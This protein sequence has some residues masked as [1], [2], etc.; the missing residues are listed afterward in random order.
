MLSQ[1]VALYFV[2]AFLANM[3]LKYIVYNLQYPPQVRAQAALDLTRMNGDTRITR[4]KNRCAL[5]GR[6]RGVMRDFRCEC[7]HEENTDDRMNRI[8][9]RDMAMEG[10]LPGVQK[11]SW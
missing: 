4:I 6:G 5:T 7:H 2:I 1:Y 9:F 11:A 3:Q 10:D 8:K